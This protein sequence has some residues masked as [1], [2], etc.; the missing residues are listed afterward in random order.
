MRT[1]EALKKMGVIV[2]LLLSENEHEITLWLETR[3]RNFN[4]CYP[5]KELGQQ[6]IFIRGIEGIIVVIVMVISITFFMI[7]IMMMKMVIS[8]I[9]IITITIKTEVVGIIIII[10][11]EDVIT[12]IINI[13]DISSSIDALIQISIHISKNTYKNLNASL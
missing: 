5:G 11:I 13:I 12:H 9:I 8:M 1:E 4:H 2:G 6:V 7:L 3:R 10:T